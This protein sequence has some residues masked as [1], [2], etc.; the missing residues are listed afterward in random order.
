MSK[1]GENYRMREDH[2]K[3]TFNNI[4]PTRRRMFFLWMALSVL[5]IVAVTRSSTR[6]WQGMNDAVGSGVNDS[7]VSQVIQLKLSGAETA[8]NSSD[9]VV[10]TLDRPGSIVTY[11]VQ[12]K[13]SGN[14]DLNIISF[15]LVAPA[16][17]EEKP[18]VKKVDNVDTNYYLGT[19][20]SAEL[21]KVNGED[22]TTKERAQMLASLDNGSLTTGDVVLLSAAAGDNKILVKAGETVSFTVAF[23]FV[24]MKENQNAFKKFCEH[25]GVCSREFFAECETIEQ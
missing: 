8:D 14:C 1:A 5:I 4:D 23:T 11:T 17:G 6:A 3:E 7:L 9:S 19:Q 25:G 20:I 12:I 22:F 10:L 21:N 24:E 16:D 13:N 2:K 18:V 15:G